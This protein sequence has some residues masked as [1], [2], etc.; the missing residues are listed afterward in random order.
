[1]IYNDEFIYVS[2]RFSFDAS[3]LWLWWPTK[4]ANFD[5]YEMSKNKNKNKS[6]RVSHIEI[7]KLC[8]KL[9]F[10]VRSHT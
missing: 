9:K 1:M 6:I 8:H 3:R 7:I 2:R 4:A 10:N 5:I